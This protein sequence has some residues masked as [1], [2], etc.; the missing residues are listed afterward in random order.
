MYNPA[1]KEGGHHHNPVYLVELCLGSPQAVQ[2]PS[3]MHKWCACFKNKK[4]GNKILH[5]SL[6]CT[7]AEERYTDDSMDEWLWPML[8][9]MLQDDRNVGDEVSS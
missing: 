1:S 5:S 8:V 6:Y 7:K 3:Q 2:K 9:E 4:M